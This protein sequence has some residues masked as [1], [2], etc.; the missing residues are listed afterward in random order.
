MP[1]AQ[2]NQEWLCIMDVDNLQDNYADCMQMI[3]ELERIAS[4]GLDQ[5]LIETNFTYFR[6]MRKRSESINSVHQLQQIERELARSE[7]NERIMTI[8]SWEQ[9]LKGLYREAEEKKCTGVRFQY[10][11]RIAIDNLLS[12]IIQIQ[13]FVLL[14]QALPGLADRIAVRFLKKSPCVWKPEDYYRLSHYLRFVQKRYPIFYACTQTDEESLRQLS[15]THSG[16]QQTFLPMLE[17][18][19]ELCTRLSHTWILQNK[20]EDQSYRNLIDA[21]AI[22]GCDD[23]EITT[24]LFKIGLKILFSELDGRKFNTPEKKRELINFLCGL[25]QSVHGITPLDMV[26]FGVLA[27]DGLKDGL[28]ENFAKNCLST[29]QELTNAIGQI[30]ENITN[31][32]ERAKGVF[33]LRLQ[34]NEEYIQKNYH[35]YGKNK[36]KRCLE[37][38]IADSNRRDNIITNFL[39]S[40]KADSE[41]KR[42][43]DSI[44]L[45]NFFG[46][47]NDAEIEQVWREAYNRRPTA[48][49][50]LR[51]FINAIDTLGG[52]AFVRSSTDYLDHIEKNYFYSSKSNHPQTKYMENKRYIPGTQFSVAVSRPMK[53]VAN[54]SEDDWIGDFDRLAYATTYRELAQALLC[55]PDPVKLILSEILLKDIG[56]V[57]KGQEEKDQSARYW[58]EWFNQFAASKDPGEGVG[59]KL[60]D[61]DLQPLCSLLEE[62]PREGEPFCKGF[63]TSDFFAMKEE[64]E[65]KRCIILR[66]ATP[67]FCIALSGVLRAI[68]NVLN[69]CN[70]CVYLY[71]MEFS[72]KGLQY[73]ATTLGSLLERMKIQ[74]NQ[75]EGSFPKIFPY[76]L[77]LRNEQGMTLFEQELLE[78][79]ERPITECNKQGYKITNTHMRLG[80]KVHLDAFYEM[81]LFFENPN[82]A[83]YTA[84]LLLRRLLKEETFVK[85]RH[86][87]FYG[88]ASYSRAI[89]WA[90]IQIYKH[91]LMLRGVPE[92]DVPEIE[93][94]IY[95]NDLKIESSQPQIQMYFSKDTWQLNPSNIWQDDTTL[96]MIVPISSSLTTFSKMKQELE[97]QT[98]LDYP[99]SIN[100]TA[101]WVRD[102]YLRPG[103]RGSEQDDLENPCE[104]PTA[105]EK[106]FWEKVDL[107]NKEITSS[108]VGTVRYLVFAISNWEN[109]LICTK[110]FPSDVL[111]EYPLVETDPTSTIP[112]QQLYL[113][114]NGKISEAA[115]ED[116]PLDWSNDARVARLKNHILYGHI[117]RS[118]NHYQYYIKT[119]TFFQQEKKEI[120]AWIKKLPPPR[121]D[122]GKHKVLNVLVIP[123]Q[124]SNVEFSQYIYEHYFKAEAECVI[125]N[126]EKEFRSNLQ[127]E[128]NGLFNRIKSAKQE[129]D[130]VLFY[131]VDTAI[132]SGASFNRIVS[133]ISSCIGSNGDASPFRF[134]KVFL[135]LC[136]LSDASKEAYVTKPK[137][138]FHAYVQVNISSMRTFGDSC[139]P[140][141]L[142]QE[143]RQ[144]HEYAATKSISSYWEGK[145]WS[146][147]CI[148][149]D[150]KEEQDIRREN[151]DINT[152]DGYMRMMCAHRAAFHIS[153]AHGK[154]I[155]AYFEA[156]QNFFQEILDA[157]DKKQVSP[158]YADVSKESLSKW[159]AAGMK[160]ISRPFFSFDY[161]LRCAVM[162]FFLVISECFWGDCTLDACR[163]RLQGTSKAYLLKHNYL[164]WIY[165]VAQDIHS[166]LQEDP[167]KEIEFVRSNILKGLAD[168]RSNYLLRKRTL[169]CIGNKLSQ[170]IMAV[171]PQTANKHICEFYQ[172]YTRSVLRLT[173]N[174]SDETKS[175][176]L[177]HLLQHG[178]EPDA[179]SN[180]CGEGI[181]VLSNEVPERIRHIFQ[182]HLELLLIENNRPL[183]QAISNDVQQAQKIKVARGEEYKEENIDERLGQYFSKNVKQFLT[184]EYGEDGVREQ[185]RCI[186]NL[187]NLLFL[188]IDEGVNESDIEH[189]YKR[190]QKQI[191]QVVEVTTSTEQNNV[192]LFG[193]IENTPISPEN[194]WEYESFY[195]ICPETEQMEQDLKVIVERMKKL[196]REQ[197][198]LE[199]DGFA[200]LECTDGSFDAMLMLDNNY[201]DMLEGD[202][203]SGLSPIAPIYIYLPCKTNRQKALMQVRKI[204]MFRKKLISWVERDF[205]NNAVADRSKK[206]RLAR[207]LAQDK[208]G[209]HT[210]SVFI[211]CM[212]KI[213]MLVDKTGKLDTKETTSIN[214][215]QGKENYEASDPYIPLQGYVG[216]TREWIL[217]HAYVNLIISRVF[218]TMVRDKHL[219]ERKE[220]EIETRYSERGDRAL[221]SLAKNLK[222]VFFAPAAS[223]FTRASYLRQ[224]LKTHCFIVNDMPDYSDGVDEDSRLNRL[225]CLI[226]NF[227]C[228]CIEKDGKTYA[229]LSEYLAVILMDC[230]IS[231]LK[232]GKRGYH[233]EWEA[234]AFVELKKLPPQEKCAI[235][236]TTEKFDDKCT[237]LVITNEIYHVETKE[238]KERRKE[239]GMSL[240]A[241]SDHINTYWNLVYGNTSNPKPMVLTEDKGKSFVTKLPIL[242][243]RREKNEI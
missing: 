64:V 120:A 213:L 35:G 97:N 69:I 46:N 106:R 216:E 191:Q 117:S 243:T 2:K 1:E 229:F 188:L 184:Y 27:C 65:Q 206:Q 209:D 183:Y 179:S 115:E 58:Q 178:C 83:Y 202:W 24:T 193:K 189:H 94:A 220:G 16:I 226:E 129:G 163:K 211:E 126:T 153:R 222:D 31:H 221:S 102:N 48:C 25:V 225:R 227:D 114:Y 43:A 36:Y 41:I 74:T 172:H 55:D 159:L 168:I 157:G 42:C 111:L 26:L 137:E 127:A 20:F 80:N 87:L 203:Q 219:E 59:Y 182:S 119:R 75:N 133:L 176:W 218:R 63:L 237:Y 164:E 151:K 214:S 205:S 17:V 21:I 185:E 204:L 118:A 101:F 239:K 11:I 208:V 135:L 235:K 60:Y 6:I 140:C 171:D 143:A 7:R 180:T 130:T 230:F 233:N 199:K 52:V 108:L 81:A 91:Y 207:I 85:G 99:S 198:C 72:G 173:H 92:K 105:I 224:L 40:S 195:C 134:E 147:A 161:W 158:V 45:D 142:Q 131:Y 104:H 53:P 212:Q 132:R 30:L 37:F 124:T 162:D 67:G 240:K 4:N 86:I 223:G 197:M 78:K 12:D 10:Y 110:C 76:T 192:I 88:Y 50:G 201:I 155:G 109:P 150:R 100:F 18:D 23:R 141:K 79:A 28:D 89:V 61:C 113:N 73:Y 187:Y 232:V 51:T 242:K 144:Y 8:T 96:V 190:L 29:I 116:I 170:S 138:N 177:E 34:D 167:V 44:T 166:L 234:D 107:E 19:R 32:S 93:F 9:L 90:A 15:N 186:R 38:L 122:Q 39:S 152:V 145:I 84:Y 174:S 210:E 13:Y 200:L 56:V 125:I 47:Y 123:Q 217:L 103:C 228:I 231:A 139:V 54:T 82:Y 77:F 98:H 136:R 156:V 160:V 215:G 196:P 149:F 5:K 128:Y 154:T 70:T 95:Q 49:Y 165:S 22:E 175:V 238:E 3:E 112:T 71:P 181:V 146:R 57:E 14:L 169:I 66:N 62:K 241:I 194:N 121:K 33:S 236:L 68:G 148:P